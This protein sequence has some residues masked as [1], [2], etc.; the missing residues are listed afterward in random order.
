MRDAAAL[1]PRLQVRG[2][3]VGRDLMPITRWFGGSSEMLARKSETALST[4]SLTGAPSRQ[5]VRVVVGVVVVAMLLFALVTPFANT[6]QPK[7]TAFVPTFEAVL[8]FCDVIAA[9][10]ILQHYAAVRSIDLLVLG[11]GFVYTAAVAAGHLLTFPNALTKGEL[12][13]GDPQTAAWIYLLWHSTF[14]LILIAYSAWD[15]RGRPSPVLQRAGERPDVKAGQAI[16]LGVLCA[17]SV[18]LAQLTFAIGLRAYL[19]HLIANGH[20][21]WT[22]NAGVAI[23]SVFCLIAAYVLLRSAPLSTIHLWLAV[24]MLVWLLDLLMTNIMA[25]GRYELGWYVGKLFGLISASTLLIVYI[26]ENGAN[27]S[28]LARLTESFEQLSMIDGLTGLSNRRSL[29]DYLL[30]ECGMAVRQRRALS[31]VLCD[32]DYFKS[33][34]DHH[35]HQAGDECLI[36]VASALKSCCRRPADLA[37]RYGGEEFALILPETELAGALLIAELARAAVLG[38]AHPHGFSRASRYVT[39]SIGVAAL[40]QTNDEAADTPAALIDAADKALF[41]A[42]ADGRN[43]VL[44]A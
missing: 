21:L 17:V 14:P 2:S 27:Y 6:P 25:T 28:R 31:L 22:M 13:G 18:A 10:M 19:P 8:V 5:Q 24:S 15:R 35:G 23:S 30:R 4:R 40:M 37:A 39:V 44:A 29:D 42:K 38:L 1:R 26:V 16:W 3:D 41:R 43:Q 20:F 12:L 11:S 34:N 32:I 9:V 7:I 36:S 33:F